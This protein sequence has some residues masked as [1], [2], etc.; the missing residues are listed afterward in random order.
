MNS[1]GAIAIIAAH[2]K[3][4]REQTIGMM[5]SSAGVGLLLGPFIGAIFYSIGG[6]LLPFFVTG[7]IILLSTFYSIILSL[8][9]SINSLLSH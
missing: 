7:N 2:Y 5:E 8:P 4:D 3:N 1:T 6:Y 9:L